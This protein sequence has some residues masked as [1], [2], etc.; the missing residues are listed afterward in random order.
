VATAASKPVGLFP[1]IDEETPARVIAD[2]RNPGAVTIA[3]HL[4]REGALAPSTDPVGRTAWMRGCLDARMRE[5]LKTAH[6]RVP[7]RWQDQYRAG[8]SARP[9]TTGTSIG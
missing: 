2:D 5:K 3:R 6:G 1:Q 7:T 8:S 4:Q 9:N